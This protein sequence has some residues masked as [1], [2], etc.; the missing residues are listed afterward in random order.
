M[1]ELVFLANALCIPSADYQALIQGETIVAMPWSFLSQ[2]QSFALCSEDDDTTHTQFWARC[3]FCRSIDIP[4]LLS[5]LSRLTVWTEEA[6]RISFQKRN[7]IFVAYLRICKMPQAFEIFRAGKGEFLSLVEPGLVSNSLPVLDGITFE[8]YRQKLEKLSPPVYPELEELQN[9][10]ARLASDNVPFANEFDQYIQ[11]FLG[12]TSNLPIKKHDPKLL[13]ISTIASLGDRSIEAES[14]KKTTYEAGTDFERIVQRSLEFLG[15]K[16]EEAYHG[17]AGGL[18]LFCSKP[19]SLVGECKS[20]KSIPDRSVEELDR[21][22]KRH[23]KKDY[24]TAARLIIG[25]GQPT[26]QLRES[27]ITSEISIISAMSLQKLVELQAKYPNS[28]N[29]IELKDY[30]IPGQIDDKIQE[31]IDKILNE[32]KLRFQMVQSVK[33]LSERESQG[34]FSAAEIRIY[35]NSKFTHFL[36]NEK[37]VYELLVELSS[38]LAGYLGRVQG[39]N[40]QSDRFYFLRDLPVD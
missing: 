18:D 2:G 1:T 31:Y 14:A 34:K 39:I 38:P 11:T 28:I 9:I 16:V 21:I 23:L 24:M 37:I 32:I 17:G 6:L 27:A 36:D 26:K 25:S 8:Q 4:E 30:L 20:G 19:Y 40:L 35:H 22:G 10:I 3:E 13:W 7:Y 12:W 15:F 29:L 33:E 5:P